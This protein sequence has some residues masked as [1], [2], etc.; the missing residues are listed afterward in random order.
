MKT[1][2]LEYFLEVVEKSDIQRSGLNENKHITKKSYKR[3]LWDVKMNK[4]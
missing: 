1:I 2:K 4:R 3:E